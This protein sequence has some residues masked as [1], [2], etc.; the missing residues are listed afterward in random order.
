MDFVTGATGCIGNVLV[1][2]LLEKGREVKVLV[3]ETSDLSAIEGLDVER[4]VGDILDIDSLVE[5]FR[6]ADIVYHLAGVVTIMP[7]DRKLI[8]R[9]NHKGTVNVI[10]ACLKCGVRRLVYASSIHA[11]KESPTG[12]VIDES[13]P[14]DIKC[15]RGEYDRSKAAASLEVI[16]A[17]SN[18]LDSVVVCPTGVI[19]PY[20]F[21]GSFST[22]TFIDFARGRMKITTGGAYDFVD[23][24]DVA[25]GLVMASEKGRKGQFYILSGER[26]TMD[27]LMGMLSENSGVKP[28]GYKI[29][30]WLAGAAGIISPLYYWLARKTPRFTYYT[31]DTLRSNS[32]ISYKKA[33]RELGYNPRPIKKTVEDTFKWMRQNKIL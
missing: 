17:A 23:V 26:I 2:T 4:A 21:K 28:P 24:R 22:R 27:E 14:F 18:G 11:L 3:R 20:D 13:M 7:G 1:R 19:G 12:T 6:G 15:R 31:I 33:R 9:S 8:R 10:N 32:Y 5:A 30:V 29:P 16:K 25:D